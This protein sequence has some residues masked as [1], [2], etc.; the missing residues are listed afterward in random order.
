MSYEID[1]GP[2]QVPVFGVDVVVIETADGVNWPVLVN[3][4]TYQYTGEKV[5]AKDGLGEDVAR[6][7]YNREVKTCTI[8]CWPVAADEAAAWAVDTVFKHGTLLRIDVAARH[9]ALVGFWRVTD[10]PNTANNTDRKTVA[11]SLEWSI[12]QTWV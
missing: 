12:K 9:P 10:L 1:H 6:I 7:Y 2:G 8:N 11:L 3:D 5:V 4:I